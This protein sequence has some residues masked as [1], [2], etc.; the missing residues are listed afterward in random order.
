MSKEQ[1]RQPCAQCPFRRA[2][3]PGF[4]GGAHPDTFMQ[5]AN[6]DVRMPC[7]LHLPQGVDY[8]AAQVP[9][10]REFQAPQCAGRAV[11]WRNQIKQPR[12]A[13]LLILEAD[14]NTVFTWPSEFMAHHREGA[15]RLWK[16]LNNGRE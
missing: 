5:L 10:T 8:A 16:A 15:L 4:L 11:F 2:S 3:L 7:H 12:D 9:G 1:H 6:A 14:R 13:A